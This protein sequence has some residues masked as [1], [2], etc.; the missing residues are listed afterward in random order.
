MTIDA[1]AIADLLERL[2]ARRPLVH[3]I[4]SPV[5]MN[6]TANALLAVGASP[7]MARAEEEMDEVVARADALV[8]NLGTLEPVVLQAMRRATRAA[9][10][11]RLPWILDPVGAGFTRHRGEAA[12]ALLA[13]DPAAIRGN[14]SEIR[15][16][17][18]PGSGSGK[19][20]DTGDTVDAAADA[21]Q[22]LTRIQRCV[23]AITGPV[24]LVTDGRRTLRI[25]NGSQLMARVTGMGCAASALV[26]A[27]LAI[28]T[29][30]L[31][32]VTAALTWLG[33]AGEIA[34]ARS[35]GPGSLQFNLLDA[36]HAL[37][38]ASLR[39]HARIS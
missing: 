1:D 34:T 39:K 15:A 23:V 38:R 16:L 4:T 11:R 21:A 26:G 27:A 12:L 6:F 29:D 14:A 3:S 30:R 22:A 9:D 8:V 36:L 10:A 17:V 31:L 13:Q 7:V 20:V 33:V 2:R 25:A 19:G 24:D 18:Q 32:A 28:D 5:V 37:D 35:A